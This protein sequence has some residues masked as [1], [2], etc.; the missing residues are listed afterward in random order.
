MHFK[1]L[2]LFYVLFYSLLDCILSKQ[3]IGPQT[4][5]LSLAGRYQ[6]P[7]TVEAYDGMSVEMGPRCAHQCKLSKD[8]IA[9]SFYSSSRS[10]YLFN[11]M[12]SEVFYDIDC[13]FMMVSFK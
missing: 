10:C 1:L 7:N 4:F 6:C 5:K 9:F 8:C 2:F 12:P 11:A 3:G 13:T